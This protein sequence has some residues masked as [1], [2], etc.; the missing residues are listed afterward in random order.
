MVRTV[1]KLRTSE[2]INR[3]EHAADVSVNF[4]V[5]PSLLEILVDTL[6]TDCR[7]QSHV[8]YA[9]LLLLESLLPVGLS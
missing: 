1:Y 6:V 9:S 7:Q 2:W 3:Y 8:R 4:A 5:L